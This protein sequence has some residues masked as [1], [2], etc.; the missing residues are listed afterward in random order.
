MSFTSPVSTPPWTAAPIATTSSGFT[1]RLGSLPKKLL[2][3]LLHLRDAGGAADQD[4][5][6]DLLGALLRVGQALPGR[7]R[8]TRSIRS[9]HIY[10][11]FARLSQLDQVL[12]A[13]LIGGEERAG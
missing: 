3:D 12:G 6:V 5:L 9:S 1:E 4:H 11:N 8:A 2:H 10:S 13:G 7:A